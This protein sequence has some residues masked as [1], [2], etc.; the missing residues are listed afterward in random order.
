VSEL[1][2]PLGVVVLQQGTEE[3]KDRLLPPLISLLEG[4]A[5][6]DLWAKAEEGRGRIDRSAVTRSLVARVA[7]SAPS[8]GVLT[9]ALSQSIDPATRALASLSLLA[10][11][12]EAPSP[13]SMGGH[14][15][16][17][18]AFFDATPELLAPVVDHVAR[19][20]GKWRAEPVVRYTAR[21]D[22]ATLSRSLRAMRESMCIILSWSGETAAS[23]DWPELMTEALWITRQREARFAA[24]DTGEPPRSILTIVIDSGDSLPPELAAQN[25]IDITYPEN[26]LARATEEAIAFALATAQSLLEH[27]EVPPP[28][29]PLLE[30]LDR[31]EF[32][33]GDLL[34]AE[35]DAIVNAIGSTAYETGQ[36]GGQLDARVGPSAR[37]ALEERDSL[38]AGE[39]VLGLG[40]GRI[41]ARHII[42]T[43]TVNRP[44]DHT[45]DSVAVGAFGAF[46]TAEALPGVR[47]I[48]YPALGSGA[49][50]LNPK[51]VARAILP[52][53]V[54]SLTR[55]SSIE[56]VVF[57]LPN[58]TATAAYRNALTE[59]RSPSVSATSTVV[60]AT[61][62]FVYVRKT[63]IGSVYVGGN[64]SVGLFFSSEE[65]PNAVP[66]LVPHSAFELTLYVDATSAFHLGDASQLTVQVRDGFI[67]EPSLSLR[68]LALASGTHAIRVTVTAR[69]ALDVG[70]EVV[71]SCPITVEP[72]I[73]LPD[74]PE[75]IDRRT[76]P[77]PQPDVLLYVATEPTARSDRLRIHLT[78]NALGY[79]RHRLEELLPL[80]SDDTSAIRFAAAEMAAET[81]AS[82]PPDARAAILAF[83]AMLYDVLMPPNHELR[84][85]FGRLLGLPPRGDW[86]ITWLVISDEAAALPWELVCPH[87]FAADATHWYDE[88]LATRFVIAH[89]I[90]RRGFEMPN[91][92]PLGPL[93]VVHYGQHPEAHPRWRDAL[94]AEL[95]SDADRHLGLDI[96]KRGSP[97]FGV[98]LLRFS[99]ATDT[100]RITEVTDAR[101]DGVAGESVTRERR[102][103]FTLRRPIVSLSFVDASL[104]R[105]GPTAPR[106]ANI[107]QAWAV[108]FL[109]ARS[110]AVIGPRWTTSPSS[111]RIFYRAF[112]DAVRAD[113]PLGLAVWEAREVLRLAHPER[114]DWLAYTYFGH[115]SCEPYLVEDAEGFTLFEPIGM[116]ADQQFVAGR[117]Y[118]FRAS[119]RGE[120]PA[121]YNGRRHIRTTRLRGE[122]VRVLVA[123][124]HGGDPETYELI[125]ASGVDGDA[126]DDYY[127]PVVLVM[128][129]DPGTYKWFVQFTRGTDELRSSVIDLDV[130]HDETSRARL[131]R[132]A[133]QN[134]MVTE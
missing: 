14:G 52:G 26:T 86:P 130:V 9:D 100:G 33:T 114:A 69:G 91:E 108:P 79:E 28:P 96:L 134:E 44:N 127:R 74:I 66:L 10:N 35:A 105:G 43:C 21:P 87:G 93:G 17:Y 45:P 16:K 37:M 56:R 88:C 78:C 70:T 22:H 122:G 19:E 29:V 64:I 51:D 85:I 110:S 68:L 73:L 53:I 63:S 123:P 83:G 133:E 99:D 119:F 59:L 77:S 125:A 84:T 126:D 76:I 58:D 113:R 115:P 55:G 49:A 13:T 30:A 81:D 34:D 112:Y 4:D 75:L 36:I 101:H 132:E 46:R 18:A 103:D 98:H 129:K 42:H 25:W 95:A 31:V 6:L 24:T 20:L 109:L 71:V 94:G 32:E 72:P 54:E 128:P 61:R 7:P 2:I 124:L 11:G 118:L 41:P 82:S 104:E 40:R 107:E 80:T 117:E 120:L 15:F 12:G 27:P 48:A 62:W 116:T 38:V 60:S 90:S 3:E 106:S 8:A 121:W 97:Y 1:V 39:T 89:W 5:I 65:D 23:P 92:A 50:G 57:V 67:D 47:R 111:D 102:L 131:L